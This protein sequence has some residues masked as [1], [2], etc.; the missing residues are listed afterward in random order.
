[1]SAGPQ[2][3]Q[4]G[5]EAVADA[6]LR[7]IEAAMADVLRCAREHSDDACLLADAAASCES[8]ARAVRHAASRTPTSDLVDDDYEVDADETPRTP[9]GPARGLGLFREWSRSSLSLLQDTS[10]VALRRVPTASTSASSLSGA[11]SSADSP[12]HMLAALGGDDD[13]P[14]RYLS[15]SRNRLPKLDRS[16]ERCTSPSSREFRRTF[17]PTKAG[18][19]ASPGSAVAPVPTMPSPMSV[20]G[21]PCAFSSASL[22]SLA[23]LASAPSPRAGGPPPLLC[24]SS[25]LHAALSCPSPTSTRGRQAM[26]SSALSLSLSPPPLSLPPVAHDFASAASVGP[27]LSAALTSGACQR[28]VHSSLL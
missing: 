10:P 21:P 3:Q 25:S 5:G 26:S 13:E 4:T 28:G 12:V 15:L 7:R 8:L 1:M 24:T 11:E 16:A 17:S 22:A 2:T 6:N 18:C 20:H 9:R 14:A 19:L 23:S 27:A